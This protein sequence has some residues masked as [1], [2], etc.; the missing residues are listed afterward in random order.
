MDLLAEMDRNDGYK[1]EGKPF[2][3]FYRMAC[4]S[5]PIL[6]DEMAY[7]RRC[8]TEDSRVTYLQIPAFAR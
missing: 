7:T 6:A 3:S 2:S 5:A 1:A 8:G 4:T